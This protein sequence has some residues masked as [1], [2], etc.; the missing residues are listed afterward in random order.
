MA[1]EETQT[2]RRRHLV[3]KSYGW[4]TAKSGPYTQ[5]RDALM[6]ESGLK[7]TLECAAHYAKAWSVSRHSVLK[8][9]RGERAIPEKFAIIV[10]GAPIRVIEV[11]NMP[12]TKTVVGENSRPPQDHFAMVRSIYKMCN[13]CAG[14]EEEAVC[15][16]WD[17]PLI[18]YTN[19]VIPPKEKALSMR[20]TPSGD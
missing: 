14:D 7:S 2:R 16:Y 8:W 19:K 5:F 13:W 3:S 12:E 15:P 10:F 20:T 4:Q 9:M 17:C 18:K 1:V 11:A 6:K